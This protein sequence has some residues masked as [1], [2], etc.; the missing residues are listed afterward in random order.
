MDDRTRILIVDDDP[1]VADSLADLLER[2]G[3]ATA[4]AQGRTGGDVCAVE[5]G[6]DEGQG[7]NHYHGHEHAP[8]RRFRVAEKDSP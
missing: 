6:G 1:I 7:G 2:E 4:T 3:Y 8:A 5:S